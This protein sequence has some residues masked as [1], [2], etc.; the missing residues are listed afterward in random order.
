MSKA[1]H[2]QD[3]IQIFESTFFNA[4]NT[5][6]ICGN[7]EPIYLPADQQSPYHRIVFA[8]GFYASALHEIAHWL[9]AGEKRRLLEDYGY[10]YEPDGRTALQQAEFEKVEVVPQ[11]IE[12]AVAMSCGFK[13]D[14]SVDNLSG[15]EIDRLGFK[16]KV[17]AQLLS[18]LENG[19]SD[20]TTALLNACAQFYNT[21]P[22][23]SSM[24]NYVGMNI[25]IKK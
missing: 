6:L 10:W 23:T 17:H 21:K 1:C 19:F 5:K 12:W 15:I 24:F 4:F 20:R 8:H 3:L 13:F 22:L 7:D 25:G 16:H 2:Y 11:A 14:V 9:V 18:Y